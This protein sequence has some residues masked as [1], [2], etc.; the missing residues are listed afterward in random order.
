MSN[1][2]QMS[3]LEAEA[4]SLVEVEAIKFV[5][6]KR[7]LNVVFESKSSTLVNSILSQRSGVS[8]FYVIVLVAHSLVRETGSWASHHVFVTRKVI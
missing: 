4:M 8:E 6:S 2:V 3:V 7:R 5:I 1:K